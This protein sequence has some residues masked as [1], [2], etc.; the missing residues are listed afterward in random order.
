MVKVLFILL[1]PG[2]DPISARFPYFMTFF[3]FLSYLDDISHFILICHKVETADE[4]QLVCPRSG[5]C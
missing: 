4:G 2:E 3:D 1:L 5:Y